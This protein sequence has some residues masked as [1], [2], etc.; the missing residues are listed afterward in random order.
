MEATF[1]ERIW[2][3][4][5]QDGGV[6]ILFVLFKNMSQQVG[7]EEEE[8]IMTWMDGGTSE[9]GNNRREAGPGA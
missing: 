9:R 6:G 5:G 7:K 3:R 1:G 4:A 8:E 2:R